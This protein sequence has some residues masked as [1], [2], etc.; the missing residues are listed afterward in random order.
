MLVLNE[1]LETLS[2]RLTLLLPH[3]ISFSFGGIGSSAAIYDNIGE[4][5]AEAMYDNREE[6]RKIQ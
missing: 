1:R 5:R 2:K 6:L 4:E 3:E